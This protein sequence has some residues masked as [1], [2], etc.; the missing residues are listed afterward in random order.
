MIPFG[1]PAHRRAT[2][3]STRPRAN[4]A[5]P[6]KN[7]RATERFVVHAKTARKLSYGELVPLASASTAPTQ[8][9]VRLKRPEQ[10][11][12]IGKDIP[13][14]DLRPIA[15]GKAVFGIDATR[16]GMVYAIHRAP[17]ISGK[18]AEELR[19]CSRQAS[20]GCAAGSD[21]GFR[22]AAVRV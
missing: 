22:E 10:F 16:P 11:R 12:Y 3:W 1:Q 9:A 5:C 8:N 6:K 14:A 2:C 13:L 17:A 21:I 4:G 18:H 19:R 7:A 20:Q 15:T